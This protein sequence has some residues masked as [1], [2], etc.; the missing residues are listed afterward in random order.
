MD[1]NEK[2]GVAILCVMGGGF[3]FFGL[4][5]WFL[6]W[7][8]MATLLSQSMLWFPLLFGTVFSVIGF[9]LLYLALTGS[10][11][12]ARQKQV[13][14]V[15][16]GEPWM[17]RADWAQGR[18]NS[19]IRGSLAGVWIA[20]VLWNLCVFPY[21]WAV[22]PSA[23]Y[24]NPAAALF[25][26]PFVAAGL[27]LLFRAVRTTIAALEFGTTYFAMDSVPG[28]IGGKLRGSIHAR[29]PHSPDHGFH[30][31]LSCVNRVRTGGGSSHDTMETILWCD[32]ADLSPG[33][34]YAGPMGT[35]IPVDFHIPRDV[36]PTDNTNL[37]NQIIWRLEGMAD[38]PGLAYHD[39]FE[40]PVFRTAASSREE[41]V[42][43]EPGEFADVAEQTRRPDQMTVVVRETEEGT[44]FYFPPARN[45]R[46]AVWT[47]VLALIVCGVTYSLAQAGAPLIFP[48][49]FGLFALVLAL[50]AAQ[51]WMGTSRLL[52][53]AKVRLQAGLLGGG[54]TREIALTDVDSFDEKIQSQTL[55]GTVV[56]YYDIVLRLRDGQSLTVGKMLSS[57]RE[58]EWL[59][60]EM[61]RLTVKDARTVSTGAAS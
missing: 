55:N 6:A 42:G 38:V 20:A 22:S 57:K 24:R 37:S 7:R 16:P 18:A 12:M 44:E 58:T 53:G 48:I 1:R 8:N 30:L 14:S 25:L 27:F 35:A 10:K 28:V 41:S 46:L 4:M 36:Q 43:S 33:Q 34:F 59:V 13:Q 61:R 45:R 56:P 39:V 54:K 60:S 47:T 32:E 26:L 9:G 2:I 5:A 52:I 17:W 19:A 40:V 29:L 49:V 21:V 23:F 3:A 15:H 51:Y 31:R 50:F 11:R